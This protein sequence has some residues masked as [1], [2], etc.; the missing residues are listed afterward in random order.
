[1]RNTS[2]T[3]PKALASTG[4]GADQFVFVD[5][6]C[7]ADELG[8]LMVLPH[9]GDIVGHGQR[10]VRQESQ[11]QFVALQRH[12]TGHAVVGI[13]G[14]WQ[15]FLG[16]GATSGCVVLIGFVVDFAVY[17]PPIKVMRAAE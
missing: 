16:L 9:C 10:V 17:R 5:W 12:F 3:W 4:N 15:R 8:W 14:G 1:M 13:V 7:L 6:R 2:R 11:Q